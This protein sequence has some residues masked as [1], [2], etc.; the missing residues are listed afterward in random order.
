MVVSHGCYYTRTTGI[1]QTVWMEFVPE[2]YLHSFKFYPDAANGKVRV[3]VV[4]DDEVEVQLYWHGRLCGHS[5]RSVSHIG[6][7]HRRQ[8]GKCGK[9]TVV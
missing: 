1:W 3:E 7:L 8:S 9:S 4:A 6:S 2:K 5:V